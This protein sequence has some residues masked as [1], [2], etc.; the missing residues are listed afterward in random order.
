MTAGFFLFRL[1]RSLFTDPEA[2]ERKKTY[3]R[4]YNP[5][6]RRDSREKDISSEAKIIEEKRLN[7]D[8]E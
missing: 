7:D 6:V 4:S 5:F 3:S 2:E 8:E 1:L